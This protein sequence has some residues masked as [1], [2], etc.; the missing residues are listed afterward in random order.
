MAKSLKLSKKQSTQPLQMCKQNRDQQHKPFKPINHEH[1]SPMKG[2]TQSQES[3]TTSSEYQTQVIISSQSQPSVVTSTHSQSLLV[4]LRPPHVQTAT[5]SKPQQASCQIQT[6]S[7]ICSQ[8]QTSST[9]SQTETKLTCQY[10]EQ[11]YTHRSAL[12]KHIKKNHPGLPSSNENSIKCLE[13]NCNFTCRYLSDLRKHLTAS[14]SIPMQHENKT[15]ATIKG[16]LTLKHF[17]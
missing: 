6:S 15:F 14:H 12:F 8:P 9:P 17:T 7:R 3:M 16:M 11:K 4:N 5:H 1:K 2:F 13:D 10:C